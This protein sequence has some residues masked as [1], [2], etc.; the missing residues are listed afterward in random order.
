[1]PQAPR[2][3]V[4]FTLQVRR[5]RLVEYRQRHAEVWPEML[6][7]LRRHGWHN[8]SLFL[9][10]DG[11]L[12]GYFETADLRA[13]L[14]GMDAEPVNERWQQQMAPFFENLDGRR[15]D[16]GFLRLDEIFHLA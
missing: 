1:M 12:V 11:L 4:C 14:K 8:Y 7:A 9:R 15:P 3:R 6:D 16:E 5:E 13:A 2:E 10:P